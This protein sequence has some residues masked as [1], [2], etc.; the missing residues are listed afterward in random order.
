MIHKRLL[1]PVLIAATL[2]FLPIATLFVESLIAEGGGISIGPLKSLLLTPRQFGLM[3]TSLLLATGTTI[4]S[5]LIGVP[6]AVAISRADLPLRRFFTLACLTPLIIPPYIQAIVWTKLFSSGP[7]AQILP[8]VFSTAGGIFVFTLS[9][10]PFVTLISSSGLKSIDPS[11]EEAS[12]T[13]KDALR[14]LR[15]ITLP[16]ITPHITSGA[17]LVF[18]F[19]L[20]N[21]EV[22]DILRL[23]T[24]PIEIFINFSAFYNEKAAT[25]LSVPLISVCLFLIWGQMA[26]MKDRSY[27]NFRSSS[28]EG[29]LFHLGPLKPV[30]VGWIAFVILVSVLV[31]LW[32]LVRGAG[33]VENYAKAFAVSRTQIFYS[34]WVSALS[35]LIM[36]LFSLGAA[37]S[38][39]RE[40]GPLRGL[41]DFLIQT[42][43]GVPSIVLGIGLIHAWNRSGLGWVYETP[44]I[45]IIGLV[46]GYA[47]FV[48]KIVS[49][50][51]KQVHRE[52]EEAALLATP[53]GT[54]IFRRILLPL[55]LPGLVAGFMAGFV[56]SLS[57]LGTALLVAAP[58]TATLPIKIYNFM[59]YGAEEIV[60]ASNLIL[61]AMIGFGLAVFHPALRM[62]HR[63]GKL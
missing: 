54:R 41:L 53:R 48:V 25:L 8:S 3:K 38:L 34:L 62:V 12:L 9:F 63:W 45:L 5:L 1:P 23:K 44:A 57:N 55:C 24:Y 4:L 2:I 50:K 33:P 11:L 60:F 51:I 18:V 7:A 35:S 59:H 49:T 17:I 22:A 31:P 37:Y 42:P 28:P 30:C 10:F 14:T 26:V 58:G 47:P 56:L 52:F 61:M 19:T 13:A 39:E 16:L 27:A 32:V 46:T 6:L 43:F 21:F 20:V 29:P 15:G 36:V 40:K